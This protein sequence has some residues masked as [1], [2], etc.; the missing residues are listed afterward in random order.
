VEQQR[1][2]AA[3]E[4]RR[5]VDELVAQRLLDYDAE[6]DI[7][8][9]AADKWIRVRDAEI[10][11]R[12][13][14]LETVELE[15]LQQCDAE[16][17]RMMAEADAALAAKQREATELS[18]QTKEYETITLAEIEAKLQA[19]RR[20]N[21]TLI[22][23]I[24][25]EAR[26]KAKETEA[27]EQ[28]RRADF[29]D[30]IEKRRL[31]IN[32]LIAQVESE[33]ENKRKLA[34]VDVAEQLKNFDFELQRKRKAAENEIEETNL[35]IERKKSNMSDYEAVRIREVDEELQAKRAAAEALLKKQEAEAE[36]RRAAARRAEETRLQEFETELTR[37]REAAEE[38]VKQLQG[39]KGLEGLDNAE[40]LMVNDLLAAVERE[41]QAKRNMAE[42]FAME[43]L[44]E[45]EFELKRRRDAAEAD[46]ADLER[47]AGETRRELEDL[48]STRLR[49]IEEDVQARRVAAEADLQAAQNEAAATRRETEEHRAVELQKIE[50]ELA[51]Q[52]KAYSDLTELLQH[53]YAKTQ[54]E[55]MKNETQRHLDFQREFADKRKEAEVISTEAE[56]QRQRRVVE[57]KVEF[58]RDRAASADS[59]ASLEAEVEERRV[60][61]RAM[62]DSSAEEVTAR[63]ASLEDSLLA[64]SGELERELEERRAVSEALV[65]AAQKEAERVRTDVLSKAK[66]DVESAL[67]ESLEQERQQMIVRMTSLETS[68]SNETRRVRDLEYEQTRMVIKHG[69]LE[70]ALAAQKGQR[71]G[72]EADKLKC[73]ARYEQLKGSMS[74]HLT[75]RM[76][77]EE[78]YHGLS[79]QL[80]YCEI[81]RTSVSG[82]SPLSQLRSEC[83]AEKSRLER[84]HDEA[85]RMGQLGEQRLAS[86]E[87]ELDV[88][89]NRCN[90]VKVVD[91]K[92]ITELESELH[93]AVLA[94]SA[95]DLTS[96]L[97]GVAAQKPERLHK[98]LEEVLSDEKKKRER[99]EAEV[100]QCKARADGCKGAAAEHEARIHSLELEL[101]RA[102]EEKHSCEVSKSSSTTVQ[103][104]QSATDAKF[105]RDLEFERSR[106]ETKYRDQQKLLDAEE[107]KSIDAENERT[108]CVDSLDDLK[109]KHDMRVREIGSLEEYMQRLTA[110]NQKCGDATAVLPPLVRESGGEAGA[111]GAA[112]LIGALKTVG[113]SL[114]SVWGLFSSASAGAASI[115]ASAA[116]MGKSAA[117]ALDPVLALYAVVG[118][119]SLFVLWKLLSCC[120]RPARPAAEAPAPAAR[121]SPFQQYNTG[122]QQSSNPRSSSSINNSSSQS[123]IFGQMNGQGGGQQSPATSGGPQSALVGRIKRIMQQ[124]DENQRSYG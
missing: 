43:R 82:D 70:R 50:D 115:A 112:A 31:V 41:A 77:L 30:E 12:L 40:E 35:A 22:K 21:E 104:V 94:K 113:A 67:V 119:V 92:R 2:A 63:F 53:D 106:V 87:A 86:L 55:L 73:S 44:R 17:Q 7:R 19:T 120:G 33:T 65:A 124:D 61:L 98:E 93:H 83:T 90:E 101:R 108:R 114:A 72:L 6:I 57:F 38:L 118:A 20:I 75:Q 16:V 91:A 89:R 1:E 96:K 111:D 28:Q 51:Q 60:S 123:R 29:E 97:T 85:E 71:A 59:L 56:A 24:E 39:Q 26:K 23:E 78:A 54:K 14:E 46:I 49:Q 100:A 76:S 122:A 74:E 45:F 42:E 8:N 52:T 110:A 32:E 3:E 13:Q 81:D 37:R 109:R 36:E 69:T 66:K 25:S 58:E 121:P 11:R 62:E 68:Y 99:L 47:V 9:S 107:R 15:R 84:R 116:S 95:C 64:R 48:Q 117:A 18:R 34:E 4:R 103:S 27:I 102:N 5:A 105:I 88:S 10:D 80:K 79:L